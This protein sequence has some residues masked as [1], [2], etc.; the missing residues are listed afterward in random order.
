MRSAFRV[1]TERIRPNGAGLG[2]SAASSSIN[3]SSNQDAVTKTRSPNAAT[4]PSYLFFDLNGIYIA[5]ELNCKAWEIYGLISLIADHE[6][7]TV[8]KYTL[9]GDDPTQRNL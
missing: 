5:W 2:F 8:D 9:L 1:I 6:A 7:Y 4:R 3:P